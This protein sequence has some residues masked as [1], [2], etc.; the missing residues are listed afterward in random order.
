MV[1]YNALWEAIYKAMLYLDYEQDCN[2]GMSGNS[3]TNYKCH[4]IF[5]SST[6]FI[7][8]PSKFKLS[9]LWLII[10][11]KRQYLMSSVLALVS[12]ETPMPDIH[13]VFTASSITSEWNHSRS[14][15][16]ESYFP[17]A[18]RT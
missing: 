15:Y 17:A 14:K 10:G 11:L 7:T 3:H 13:N 1:I 2:P 4:I 16:F 12:L 5:S 6:Q 18:T 8:S 9:L